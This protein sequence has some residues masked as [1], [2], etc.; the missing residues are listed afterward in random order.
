MRLQFETML[1]LKTPIKEIAEFLGVSKTTL[2]NEKK[3]GAYKRLN[4]T[5][6]EYIEDYSADIADAKYRQ[7]LKEK[8]ADI[9][10]GKDYEYAEYLEHRIVDD[11]LSPGAVLGEIKRNNMHFET[12]ISINTLYKYIERGYFS[13]LDL[14]HLP[15]KNKKKNH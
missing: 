4:G 11:K 1:K 15:M 5:T 10:L 9:K 13:R 8:G 7:H 6:W 3:R 2:Y 12:S 14:K